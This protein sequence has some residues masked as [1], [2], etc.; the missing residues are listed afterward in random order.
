[1]PPLESVQIPVLNIKERDFLD[2]TEKL[3][4]TDNRWEA[5][6]AQQVPLPRTSSPCPSNNQ[7]GSLEQLETCTDD[8]MDIMDFSERPANDLRSPKSPRKTKVMLQNL[9]PPPGCPDYV[10]MNH[11]VMQIPRSSTSTSR[12]QKVSFRK[13]RKFP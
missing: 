2:Q 8:D 1:M 10:A 6:I 5:H 12:D 3:L 13:R 9:I 11:A 7:L 4:G